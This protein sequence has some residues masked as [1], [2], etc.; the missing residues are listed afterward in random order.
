MCAVLCVYTSSRIE[1]ER[2]TGRNVQ[3]D[4]ISL[5]IALD[6][7]HFWLVVLLSLPRYCPE[8]ICSAGLRFLK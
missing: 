5:V 2:L 7:D 1:P 6:F 3:D 8:L 4:S